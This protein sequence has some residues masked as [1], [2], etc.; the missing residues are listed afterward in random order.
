MCQRT[1]WRLV[2]QVL[3]C[4]MTDVTGRVVVPTLPPFVYTFTPCP[5]FRRISLIDI[6]RKSLAVGGAGPAV[7]TNS[8][9]RRKRSHSIW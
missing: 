2:G 8:P 4:H 9:A 7:P 5:L 3:T 1:T 6:P